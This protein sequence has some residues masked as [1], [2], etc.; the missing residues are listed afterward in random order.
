MATRKAAETGKSGGTGRSGRA[1]AGAGANRSPTGK[2]TRHAG[3]S[4]PVRRR[5]K[6]AGR[7][8]ITGASAGI[9]AELARVFAAHGHDLVLV[10][11]SADK[12]EALATELGN[13]HGVETRVIPLDLARRGAPAE[14]VATLHDAGVEID[15]L[16]NNAGVIEVGRFPAIATDRM[17]QLLDLNAGALTALTSVLLPDMVARG[18]GRILNV[19]SIAAFQPVPS[20][21]VYAAT[22]AYVLSLT[23]ALSEELRGTGVTLTA[24]CPGL[25]DT[26]MMAGIQAGSATARGIPSLLVSSPADVARDGYEAL[27]A[28]EVVRVAGLGNRIAVGWSRAA[29]RWLVRVVAG[30]AS[31]QADWMR[32]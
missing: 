10:A 15:I 27:M 14:L 8:L 24:L 3:G 11:R 6:A 18:R 2:A 16:V 31:R 28:G 21:A 30:L 26:D 22:K 29:P 5:G 1:S 4:A 7:A 12:L 9:G 32:R 23:E 20:M 13:A 25:T 17:L 19:A